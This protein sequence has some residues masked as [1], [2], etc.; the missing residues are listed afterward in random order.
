MTRIAVFPGSFDPVTLGHIDII[1]RAVPLFDKIII[2][3]GKNSQ[4]Q[5][6]FTLEQRLNWLQE[7]YVHEQKISV[8]FYEGLTVNYCAAKNAG[9][10]IRGLRSAADY[11]YEKVIAQTNKTLNHQIETIFIL[12]NPEFSHVSSTIVKEVLRNGGD[13]TKMVPLIVTRGA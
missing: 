3:I 4:K 12:S 8:D 6:Y 10:I 11:E 2:A 9:Y 1:E 13:I 5:G 7:L